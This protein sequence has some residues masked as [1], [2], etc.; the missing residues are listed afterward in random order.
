MLRAGLVAMTLGL[1]VATL[2]ALPDLAPWWGLAGW[3]L[4][5]IGMG[6]SSSTLSVLMLDLSPDDQ[7]GR[8]TSHV[9]FPPHGKDNTKDAS[10]TVW[11]A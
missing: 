3:A 6:I 2:L 8:N 5:G 1:A 4:A 11:G 7:Q 10:S 9:H